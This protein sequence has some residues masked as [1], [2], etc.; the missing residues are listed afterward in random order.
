MKKRELKN[1]NE[2][3]Y[4]SLEG[5]HITFDNYSASF[6]HASSEVLS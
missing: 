2:V 5:T 1:I 4:D 3:F 6:L